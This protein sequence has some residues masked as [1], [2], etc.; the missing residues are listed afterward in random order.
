[1]NFNERLKKTREKRKMS[2]EDLAS[3]VGITKQA[4]FK[5]EKGFMSPQP[6]VLAE[7]AKALE[8]STDYLC[9]LAE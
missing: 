8:V 7:I 6:V 9:G 2:L 4:I 5:Y 3:K 1:M